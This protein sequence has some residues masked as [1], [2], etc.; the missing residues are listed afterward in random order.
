M[1]Q[2]NGLDWGVIVLYFG[3]VF[4]VAVWAALT[5]RKQRDNSAGYFLAGRNVG[6]FVIGASMFASNIGSEHLVG[7]AGAGASTGVVLGQFG[8]RLQG[9]SGESGQRTLQRAGGRHAVT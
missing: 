6:W 5:N 1:G 2:L 3:V 9:C 8:Q 4:G 7:L